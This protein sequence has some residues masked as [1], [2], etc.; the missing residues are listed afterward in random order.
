MAASAPVSL[1]ERRKARP[2]EQWWTKHHPWAQAPIT[3]QLGT[4]AITVYKFLETASGTKGWC[5]FSYQEIAEGSGVSRSTVIRQIKVLKGC[6]A[7]SVT[8]FP[9]AAF[10]APGRH[11]Y[12]R[13]K[14]TLHGLPKAAPRFAHATPRSSDPRR[15]QAGTVFEGGGVNLKPPSVKLEPREEAEERSTLPHVSSLYREDPQRV[16]DPPK[17]VERKPAQRAVNPALEAA[18]K[19]LQDQVGGW[20]PREDAMLL[21]GFRM[22]ARKAHV[23]LATSD[24]R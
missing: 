9:P 22:Q 13:N 3:R 24:N 11:D 18:I 21:L 2:R 4:A 12:D 20:L 10:G 14:Y 8:L 7:T 16:V 19:Q 15:A 6:G 23:A 5:Q 17:P 1:V